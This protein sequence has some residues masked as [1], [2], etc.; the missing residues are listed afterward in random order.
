MCRHR[1]RFPR[2]LPFKRRSATQSSLTCHLLH[3][4]LLETHERLLLCRQRVVALCGGGRP[5][6]RGG[7]LNAGHARSDPPPAA[8]NMPCRPDTARHAR[9]KGGTHLQP[10]NPNPPYYSAPPNRRS[11]KA[12]AL[13]SW[14][15]STSSVFLR[16]RAG[17]PGSDGKV[18]AHT[19]PHAYSSTSQSAGRPCS[20]MQFTGSR[21]T[22]SVAAL[23]RRVFSCTPPL[24][25]L[26][27]TS[28]RFPDDSRSNGL[29]AASRDA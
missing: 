25:F 3:A 19:T 11:M 15:Y 13:R 24:V 26:P 28:N 7:G 6:E 9:H 18:I 27:S 29:E 23:R 16:C 17:G 8:L 5:N 14:R 20:G 12:L 10:L 1:A 22:S 2:T 4:L 21:R